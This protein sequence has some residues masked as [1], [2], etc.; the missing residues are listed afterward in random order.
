MRI[1]VQFELFLGERLEV[2]AE[3]LGV[4]CKMQKHWQR[5]APQVQCGSHVSGIVWWLGQVCLCHQYLTAPH[6][7]A[8]LPLVTTLVV[9]ASLLATCAATSFNNP[10]RFS[11][12]LMHPS[13]AKLVGHDPSIFPT[14][15]AP[16]PLALCNLHVWCSREI[17]AADV[18]FLGAAKHEVRELR[19]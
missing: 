7:M 8:W 17:L 16:P 2:F 5:Q 15:S 1:C 10:N 9:A 6:V 12:W 14:S 3:A 18:H 19:V 11:T 13:Q 4:T